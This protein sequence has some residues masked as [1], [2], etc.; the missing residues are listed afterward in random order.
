M[1]Y[2]I[3]F[4]LAVILA[5]GCQEFGSKPASAGHDIAVYHQAMHVGDI[6][7][8]IYAIHSALEVE[9]DSKYYDTLAI[10]YF[11][12]GRYPQAAMSAEEFLKSEPANEKMLNIAAR[13]YEMLDLHD[14]ALTYFNKLEA[15]NKNPEY[16]YQSATALFKTNRIAE[17]KTA[18]EK[19]VN[20][21]R[22]DTMQ[23]IISNDGEQ[24]VAPLKSAAFN[25][26]GTISHLQN[27]DK[28]AK[29]YFDA[30]LMLYP[31]F[32]LAKNNI[33]RLKQK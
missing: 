28:K 25:L 8:A 2:L 22:A 5:A 24:E 9:K 29:A 6:N 26:L 4:F 18:A 27:D 32:T 10:L 7:T 30:S 11:R 17:A 12:N 33:E 20:D 3:I 15:I 14:S 23:M 31:D 19:V 13:S 16:T 1:R 21:P